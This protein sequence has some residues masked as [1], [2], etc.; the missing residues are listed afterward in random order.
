MK[1]SVVPL[2][3]VGA[4]GFIVVLLYSRCVYFSACECLDV[5]LGFSEFYR[6]F[7]F[8]YSFFFNLTFMS[9]CCSQ[10]EYRRRGWSVVSCRSCFPQW[11]RIPSGQ[12][13][14]LF[15]SDLHS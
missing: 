9:L 1:F 10:V 13:L 7:F 4:L 8:V 2:C 6:V 5:G 15:T 12:I 3:A 14:C 11:S